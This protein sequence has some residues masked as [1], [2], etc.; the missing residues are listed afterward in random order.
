MPEGARA[1]V[2]VRSGGLC[3]GCG[4]VRATEVHH[5]KYRSRGVDHTVQN[6]LHLCGFGNTSGC[7]GIAHG[8]HP[9]GERRPATGWA[10]GTHEDPLEVAV[11]YRGRLRHLTA[12]GLTITPNQYERETR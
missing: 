6:L 5:R 8:V 7:H 11:L 3:E 12:E 10:V 1:A 2:E 9:S 4:D